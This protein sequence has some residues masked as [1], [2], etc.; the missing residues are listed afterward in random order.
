MNR[1][2]KL[3]K[4]QALHAG[5]YYIT[6]GMLLLL[7]HIDELFVKEKRKKKD[8]RTRCIFENGTESDIFLDTL[9]RSITSDG[10]IVTELQ[11]ADSG[12]L[13]SEQ[14]I[15]PK[16]IH[17]GW[18]YVLKSLSEEPDI[19]N[20]DHL[21]KIGFTTTPI[22]QR[23]ANAKNE[24]TYL[25]ENVECIAS[26][27]TFNMHTQ[28][29]ENLIHQ[30]FSAVK[31][32]TTVNDNE[33]K[34]HHPREW[35]VVPLGIIETV[36]NRIIDRSILNYRYNHELQS[37]ELIEGKS[38]DAAPKSKYDTKGMKVLTLIIKKVFFD[39]IMEGEKTIEYRELRPST[40][41]RY[42]WQSNED[43]KRY[44]KEFD[45]IRFYVGYNKN[46]KSALVELVKTT[47]N[48][49]EHEVEYHLGKILE[50]G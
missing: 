24:P 10:Y 19:K 46:R 30:V 20:Q 50:Q 34:K 13:F 31:F 38:D 33:G 48:V 40:L 4:T 11:E 35:Y 44:L 47:Y 15:D 42:T 27:K 45:A 39:L 2:K 36:V 43:G 32:H 22:E 41:N 6:G 28:T 1:I 8:A 49:E 29:F 3:T 12:D 37:L 25:M 26:W 9:R 21:Y 14:T 23:I 18:I 5:G 7:E 17:D 16:D